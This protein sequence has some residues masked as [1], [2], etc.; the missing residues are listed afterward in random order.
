MA[1]WTSEDEA[2]WHQLASIPILERTPAQR[3]QFVSLEAQR[4]I[5]LEIAAYEDDRFREKLR[6]RREKSGPFYKAAIVVAVA[7]F[8]SCGL[9]ISGG[10]GD[11][12]GAGILLAAL[13]AGLNWLNQ[14][15]TGT[16]PE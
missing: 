7:A 8:G 6:S 12:I 1:E 16:G 9:G 11:L 3:A 10:S 4:N 13:S 15:L 5:H 2:R 14:T